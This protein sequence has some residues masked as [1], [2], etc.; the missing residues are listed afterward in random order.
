MQLARQPFGYSLWLQL[1]R[2][3]M[4]RQD[5]SAALQAIEKGLAICPFDPELLRVKGQIL[6]FLG[7]DEEAMREWTRSLT[8]K[9]NQ[10]E[11]EEY[12]AYL[13]SEGESYAKPYAIALADIQEA[14]T[15]EASSLA[16]DANVYYLLRQT[17]TQVNK[18]G[19]RRETRHII[20]KV[21]TEKGCQDFRSF[22]F[23]Y[24]PE[25]E[26]VTI[27][28]AQV[29]Q[30]DGTL[31]YS[32]RVD[33]SSLAKLMGVS[34]KL[35][36]DYVHKIIHLP[37]VQTN[38]IIELEYEIADRMPNLYTDYFG[39][40]YFVSLYD[41]AYLSQYVL[42]TP[43]ERTFLYKTVGMAIE[44]TIELSSDQSWRTYVWT[45]HS[46]PNIEREP[47][48]PP[49]SEVL[50]YL[51][52]TTFKDWEEVAA[53]YWSLVKQQLLLPQV[54]K[55]KVVGLTHDARTP[56]EKARA[57]YNFVVTEIRYLGLEFGAHGYKP[58]EAAEVL[59]AQYGDCKDK[60]TL[61]MAMLKEAGIS[62]DIVLVRTRSLGKMDH[63]L[64][65]LGLFNHAILH[66][67]DLNGQEMW[68]DGTAQYHSFQ[69]LPF[70]DQGS[71]AFVINASGGSF[72]QIPL[73][74]NMQNEKVF[75]TEVFISADGSAYGKR[76]VR[77][78]GLPAPSVRRYYQNPEK[79]KPLVEQALN[80]KYPGSRVEK[81]E[82]SDVQNLDETP[83][84][85]YTFAIPDFLQLRNEYGRF[86]PWL[87]PS[88]LSQMY[89]LLSSRKYDLMISYPETL[90]RHYTFRLDDGFTVLSTPEPVRMETPFG[91]FSV[92]FEVTGNSIELH[93][94]LATTKPRITPKEYAAFRR[95]CNQVD[96][97]Q[98]TEVVVRRVT[99]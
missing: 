29:I 16:R 65:S 13:H 92:R 25:R 31:L 51:T 82:V 4:S 9:E 63:S 30:P 74:S 34:M 39:D 55:D 83:W 36:G 26:V 96:R 27:K 53:W 58:H 46:L 14:A 78:R 15:R 38:S 8:V 62:S 84:L 81:V 87:L 75:D 41:P 88:E 11:L 3:R 57:L 17:I 97:T 22:S 80:S 95:F 48:M 73:S 43:A 49:D 76:T 56:L 85:S 90:R 54:L 99:P 72:K 32:D 37:G 93:E 20:A 6:H 35:Y 98:E 66:T 77:Y 94:E 2:Q 12:I 59:K 71:I 45:A 64:A 68:L 28:K 52:I 61:L 24:V 42:I 1:A 33:D 60:A 19:S 50:P 79:A 86:K 18:D 70:A 40:I 7:H 91:L 69:E 67:A 10:P 23:G 47:Y 44:P 89:A 5:Y 21:L